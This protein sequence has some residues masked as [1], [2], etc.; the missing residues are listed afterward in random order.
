MR[1]AELDERSLQDDT[2][3][4][5]FHGEL[6]RN[7]TTRVT[8]DCKD[9]YFVDWEVVSNDGKADVVLQSI[10]RPIEI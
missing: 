10:M 8:E 2:A 3:L 9:T 4:D 5:Q 6:V 7:L 1:I